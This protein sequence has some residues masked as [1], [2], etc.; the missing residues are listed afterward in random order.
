MKLPKILEKCPILE[1]IVEIRFSTS[2]PPQASDAAFGLIY[3]GIKGL[4]PNEVEKLP[5]LQIP[6]QIRTFE[7]KFE[8]TPLYRIK[9][10][11]YLVQIGPKVISI[12][13]NAQY[14]GWTNFSKLIFETFDCLFSLKLVEIIHRIGVR[15][16]NFFDGDIVSKTNLNVKFNREGLDFRKVE[17]RTVIENENFQSNLQI[18]NI[19]TVTRNAT[20]MN[21]SLIDVDTY[22]EYHGLPAVADLNKIVDQAHDEEKRIFFGTLTDEFAKELGAKYDQ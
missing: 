1:S 17:F 8:F 19:A 20:S 12:V 9:R 7:K 22:L 10:D 18:S 6:E 14:A 4:F 11:P 2:L 13:N 5:A 21:G 15:Y 16:I 3:N